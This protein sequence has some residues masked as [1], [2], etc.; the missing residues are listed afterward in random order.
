MEMSSVSRLR[1]LCS[2]QPLFLLSPPRSTGSM[3]TFVGID[4]C[5]KHEGGEESS[6][7]PEPASGP[8]PPA[9]VDFEDASRDVKEDEYREVIERADGASMSPLTEHRIDRRL[10]DIWHLICC[11]FGIELCDVPSNFSLRNG[12][13]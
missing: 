8:R 7:M 11:D 6:L 3:G 9:V 1:I 4:E 12:N 10:Q 2:L 13:N 5:R